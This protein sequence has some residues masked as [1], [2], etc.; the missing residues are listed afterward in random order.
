MCVCRLKY[1]GGERVKKKTRPAHTSRWIHSVAKRAHFHRQ[2]THSPHG[3]GE[4]EYRQRRDKVIDQTCQ[5]VA[6]NI[7]FGSRTWPSHERWIFRHCIAS[8]HQHTPSEYGW[9]VDC[10]LNSHHWAA[11]HIHPGTLRALA[12]SWREIC[13]WD[14]CKNPVH[15]DDT[16]DCCCSAILNK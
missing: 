1:I 11:W 7:Y 4:R 2:H 12:E 14:L 8:Q 10:L 13:N 6:A 9:Y 3:N 5:N 16:L 15:C